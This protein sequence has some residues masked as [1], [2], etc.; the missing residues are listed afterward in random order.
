MN[1]KA[2]VALMIVGA[3]GAWASTVYHMI[4][5]GFSLRAGAP[6][7]FLTKY[8]RFNS[9]FYPSDLTARGRTY[10]KR[11]LVSASV[12]VGLVLFTLLAATMDA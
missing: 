11:M 7:R 5:M 1:I 10:R 9:V 4:R 3:I 8:N 2:I 6:P 12:F